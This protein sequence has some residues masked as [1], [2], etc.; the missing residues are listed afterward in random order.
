MDAQKLVKMAND[1]S[2]FFAVEPVRAAAAEGVAGHL[3][4]FWEPR[5]RRELLALHD[6]GGAH[7]L[8]DLVVEALRTHRQQLEPS[9][10]K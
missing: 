7:G 4:R 2:R 9:P 10:A 8:E 6:A 5:M 3:R 1:I